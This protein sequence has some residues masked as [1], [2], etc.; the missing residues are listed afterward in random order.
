MANRP[1]RVFAALVITAVVFMLAGLALSRLIKS[2]AQRALDTAAPPT[3]RL[4]A[5]VERPQANGSVVTRGNLTTG[6]SVSIGPVKSSSAASVITGVYVKTGASATQGT[7]LIEVSGRPVVLL[8]GAFPA[9]RDLKVG[10]SGPD[11]AQLNKAL[12]AVGQQAPSSDEYTTASAAALAGLYQKLGYQAPAGNVFDM[13]E[14]VFVPASS[15][16]VAKVTARVGAA[17]SGKDLV[18]LT[19]GQTT[20]SAQLPPESAKT[21]N[22]GDAATVDLGDAGS[23][24]A[25][26]TAVQVGDTAQ[27]TTVTLTPS[28]PLPDVTQVQ[29][30]KVTIQQ[31]LTDQQ[32]LSVPV[33]AVYA[34]TDGTTVVIVVDKDGTERQVPVKPGTIVGGVVLVT[35]TS[36]DKPLK[37]GDEVVVSGQ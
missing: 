12:T 31:K 28:G 9:Y 22:K 4:T 25:T 19:S 14:F 36:A 16:T 27:N 20:I 3:T 15:A 2:P 23:A 10:D 34:K 37:L 33:S 6:S 21:L 7:R 30:V 18:V 5:P 1:G 32:A 24:P 35:P 26:V 13:R 8:Q 11:A 29:D 17:A